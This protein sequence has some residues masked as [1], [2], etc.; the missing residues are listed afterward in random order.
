MARTVKLNADPSVAVAVAAE[1]IAG[2][3]VTVSTNDWVVVPPVFFAV[4][5]TG[6]VPALAA[7][8]VPDS[9]AVP[10]PLLLNETPAGS[11]PLCG[12]VGGVRWSGCPPC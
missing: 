1:V 8:G 9:V 2:G 5:V 11:V 4:N 3:P 7:V 12:H 10:L 6:Y